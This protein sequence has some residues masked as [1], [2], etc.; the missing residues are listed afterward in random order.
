MERTYNGYTLSDI[1]KILEGFESPTGMFKKWKNTALY[2]SY[3]YAQRILETTDYSDP[4][5][6]K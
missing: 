6:S 3:K 5:I 2:H 4:I 1:C